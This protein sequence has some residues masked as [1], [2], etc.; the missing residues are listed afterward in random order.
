MITRVEPASEKEL[1]AAVDALASRRRGGL[2]FPAWLERRFEAET[3][4]RYA[5]VL[6]GDM[7]KVIV[8]YNFFLI[9]DFVLAPDT[10]L[11][12]AALHALVVTPL[13]LGLVSIFR[14]HSG[15]LWRDA[16]AG[17]APVL[18]VAQILVVFAVS[19]AP[20]ASHYPYFVIMTTI[21]TNTALRMRNRSAKWATYFTLALTAATLAATAKLT[22]GLAVIQCFS[23]AVCGLATLNGNHD[24]EREF[25]VSY[26]RGLRDRLRLDATDAEARRD[27]LTEL[28]NRR[29]LD[30]AAARVWR[31]D[32]LGG[33]AAVV[34]FDVD[35]FKAFN[36]LYG[37]PAGDACLRKIAEASASVLSG[38]NAVLARIGGEEF[39]ALLTGDAA[40]APEAI[41][42]QLR[43]AVLALDVAPFGATDRRIVS[44]SFGVAS[45]RIGETS[46]EAL[47]AA[48][49]A[50]LYAAK[51]AGRNKVARALAA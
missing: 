36:D 12:A 43:Q 15:P 18:I 1:L 24:R 17:A 48:A 5:R 33:A 14:S 37:H 38:R 13:L 31:S 41:A 11:L 19:K 6:I 26:L 49:D 47:T 34:I 28:A 30:E 29:A 3:G 2:T 46:F 35:N 45:G 23:L 20:M 8:S 32:A 16:A 4:A 22:P 9:V 27:P 39:L 51:S 44:S 25:R 7:V 10:V 40:A 50:A 42:E 21:S